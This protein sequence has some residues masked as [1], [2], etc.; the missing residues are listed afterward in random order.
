M[1]MIASVL[2][3]APAKAL[4]WLLQMTGSQ[5]QVIFGFA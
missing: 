2:W 1:A 5:N 3:I 4:C